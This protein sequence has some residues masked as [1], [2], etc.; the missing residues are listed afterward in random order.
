MTT[1]NRQIT[2]AERPVGMPKE[3]DFRL[4]EC[5]TPSPGGG[6]VL[7]Q[8]LYLSV[9][10]YMRGRLTGVTTY[11]RGLELG[12]VMVG[13][14]VGRGLESNDPRYSTGD[15]V[16]G[17]LGWGECGVAPAKSLR[18]IGPADGPIS[19]ALYVLGMPGLTAYFGL[20]EIC[21]PQPGETVV[22]S[23][24]AGGAG[25]GGGGGARRKK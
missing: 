6:E 22:A 20:L 19:S 2:L 25:R 14:A 10:P 21:R 18:K 17:M 23:G 4:E 11:A 5:P 13:G 9:D 7:V 15:I 3:S 12:E 16:E 24:A 8:A 1:M